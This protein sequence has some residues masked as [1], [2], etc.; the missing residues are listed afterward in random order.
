MRT[1][2]SNTFSNNN[3]IFVLLDKL[4]ACDWHCAVADRLEWR[5]RAE[6][7]QNRAQA[8]SRARLS[9]PRRAW[10]YVKYDLREIV[11]PSSIPNPPDYVP[12]P[13]LGVRGWLSVRG[14]FMDGSLERTGCL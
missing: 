6:P 8:M 14:A 10:Y 3:Y 7:G 13:K 5:H 4:V 12:E 1:D 11:A 9:L 2:S